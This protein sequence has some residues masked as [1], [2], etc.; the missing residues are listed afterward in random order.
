MAPRVPIEL[1]G[2]VQPANRRRRWE[3]RMQDRG[4]K[5]VTL[6][7]RD[8][9]IPVV[10]ALKVAL[11]V[12]DDQRLSAYHLA[13][14]RLFDQLAEATEQYL[15][16]EPLRW[17]RDEILADIAECRAAAGTL[18]NSALVFPDHPHDD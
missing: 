13:F 8:P 15:F 12:M 17:T 9:H 10:E 1:Q 3:Q 18:R 11:R 16:E 6:Y 5:R 14:A 7:A 2:E 4:F